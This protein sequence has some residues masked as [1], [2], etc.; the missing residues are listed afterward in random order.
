MGDG[1]CQEGKQG[2]PGAHHPAAKGK[3]PGQSAHCT[4]KGHSLMVKPLKFAESAIG[5]A[6]ERN[7]FC[8]FGIF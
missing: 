1:H 8:H 4:L 2:D 5:A 7:N 6:I 3:G